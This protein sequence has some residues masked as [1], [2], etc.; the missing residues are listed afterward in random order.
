MTWTEKRRVRIPDGEVAVVE[1][2]DPDAPPVVLLSGG[3]TSSYLWRGL[4]PL[5]APW[6]HVIAPDLL[7]SGDSDSPEDADLRLPA[8]TDP[9]WRRSASNA[10]PWSATVAARASHSS[11]RSTGAWMRSS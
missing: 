8:Q 6:M 5:L 1:A 9:C 11:W 4:I 3:F 7:G 2:G 10:S